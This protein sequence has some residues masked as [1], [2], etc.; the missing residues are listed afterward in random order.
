MQRGY[1]LNHVTGQ[2]QQRPRRRGAAQ[3]RRA[4]RAREHRRPGADLHL[5]AAGLRNAHGPRPRRGRLLRPRRDRRRQRS[6]R[7]AEL[8]GRHRSTN[9]VGAKKMLIKNKLP[10]DESKNKIVVHRQGLLGHHPG[11]GQPRRSALRRR[12]AG[13]VKA[14]L[15]FSSATSGESHSTDLPCGNWRLL[16]SATSPKGYKYRDSELDDGDGQDRPLEGRQAASRPCC[17]ARARRTL[18]YDLQLGVGQGT[19][20]VN[21][22]ERQ[23]DRLQRLPGLQRQGRHATASSSSARTARRRRACP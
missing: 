3:R 1:L 15:T 21:V 16:G 17:R 8:P 9:R 20:A 18:D 6:G 2:F 5:R 22:R 7:S 10:D 14:T 4:A 19:V 12:P 23:Q 13:T 11:A